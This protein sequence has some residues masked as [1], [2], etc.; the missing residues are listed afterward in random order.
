MIEFIFNKISS[1][2]ILNYLIPG[3]VL[4]LLLEYLL[5]WVFLKFGNWYEAGVVF[6]FVGMV[7]SRI[8]S[9]AVEPVLKKIWGNEFCAYRDYVIAE[10]IDSAITKLNAENNIFRSFISVSLMLLLAMIWDALVDAC[11][12]VQSCGVILVVIALFVLFVCAYLKQVRY[13]SKRVNIAVSRSD[14]NEL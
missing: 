11:P 7:N 8:G 12:R 9:L 14:K 3:T 4:C 13:I 1:Y 6:Y 2:N 5:G 10:R